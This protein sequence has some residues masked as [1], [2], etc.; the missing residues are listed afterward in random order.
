MIL[1]IS[2]SHRLQQAI[3]YSQVQG[4]ILQYNSN[5]ALMTSNMS[6]LDMDKNPLHV[7]AC[8]WNG[9]LGYRL[10]KESYD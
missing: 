2:T 7:P 3:S 10:G 9:L 1:Q 5:K 8:S 4:L 6:L